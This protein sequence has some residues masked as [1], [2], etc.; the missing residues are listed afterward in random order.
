MFPRDV[1]QSSVMH[2]G[3]GEKISNV[4]KG[5]GSINKD[6]RSVFNDMASVSHILEGRLVIFEPFAF[7]EIL[8]SVLYRLLH[9]RPLSNLAMETQVD[10]L[11]CLGLLA[12]MST[13]IFQPGRYKLLSYEL[14]RERLSQ[15]LMETSACA[16]IDETMLFWILYV[17]AISVLKD[18]NMTWL[19]SRIKA[20]ASSLDI[21]DW[22]GARKQLC[23]YPWISV[24]HDV[25]AQEL[26][27]QMNET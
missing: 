27:N 13:T 24:F 2:H 6:L 15:A 12:F 4:T 26:W 16:S 19:K 9:L 8:I 5:A 25:T 17:G 18:D 23:R 14:L 11:C 20:T 7:Q 21:Q 10:D 1:V 22:S 3:L